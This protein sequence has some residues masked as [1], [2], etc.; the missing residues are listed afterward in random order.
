[1]A[2]AFIIVR[3]N[4]DTGSR[5]AEDEFVGLIA[6]YMEKELDK[7]IVSRKFYQSKKLTRNEILDLVDDAVHNAI[8][9]TEKIAR[10]RVKP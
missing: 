5:V 8:N 6:D 7:R 3:D 2:L 10:V 4:G 9:I 1:M